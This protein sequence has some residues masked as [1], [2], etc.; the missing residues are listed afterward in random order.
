MYN[1]F[2]SGDD[3]IFAQSTDQRRSALLHGLV[4]HFSLFFI[5]PILL[6]RRRILN[7]Q[8]FQTLTAC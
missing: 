4:S 5:S 8:L 2:Q 7:R 1:M 3:S 6:P